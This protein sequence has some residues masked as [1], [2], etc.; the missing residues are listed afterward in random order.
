MGQRVKLGRFTARPDLHGRSG[1]LQSF[2]SA[3]GRW[4][5][6]LEGGDGRQSV[7]VLPSHLKGKHGPVPLA[8]FVAQQKRHNERRK[9]AMAGQTIVRRWGGDDRL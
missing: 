5:V 8:D 4:T 7:R 6:Q 3:S 9:V 1:V 2:D